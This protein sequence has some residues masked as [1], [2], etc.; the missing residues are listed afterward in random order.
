MKKFVSLLIIC[1][2]LISG[3]VAARMMADPTAGNASV[4]YDNIGIVQEID[5][6]A[7]TIVIDSK[8]Y[9]FASATVPIR[10]A[11]GESYSRKLKKNTRIGFNTSKEGPNRSAS[12]AEIWVL[13]EA[14]P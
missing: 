5:V 11:D 6:A 1:A 14:K 2:G 13:N 8:R 12:V 7:R 4:R 3:P 9:F 10:S